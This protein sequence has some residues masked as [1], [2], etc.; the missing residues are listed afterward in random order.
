[1]AEFVNLDNDEAVYL[2]D[3]SGIAKHLHAMHSAD[4][5]KFHEAEGIT[6][7]RAK[8]RLNKTPYWSQEQIE[9]WKVFEWL[10]RESA[11]DQFF[12]RKEL[13]QRLID[14]AENLSKPSSIYRMSKKDATMRVE[15]L[16]ATLAFVKGLS[17]WAVDDWVEKKVRNAISMLDQ[18]V[19]DR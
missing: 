9:D 19:Y 16:E 8:F 17:T 14:I 3:A 6:T 4:V 5:I 11:N 13:Q 12:T 18:K 10:L 1:M 15:R 7:P 2:V